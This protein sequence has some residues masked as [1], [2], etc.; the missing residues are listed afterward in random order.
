[1]EILNGQNFKKMETKTFNLNQPTGKELIAGTL[2]NDL[3]KNKKCLFLFTKLSKRNKIIFV[4]N[5]NKMIDKIKSH[6]KKFIEDHSH[7]WIDDL[8]DRDSN[9]TIF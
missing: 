1:M 5:K 4:N 7:N 8:L 6:I 3:N 9:Q 2:K